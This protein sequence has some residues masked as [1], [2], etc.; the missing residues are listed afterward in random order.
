MNKRSFLRRLN[1][2]ENKFGETQEM[3]ECG[4][5]IVKLLREYEKAMEPLRQNPNS[6][7]LELEL[8]QECIRDMIEEGI[9][10]NPEPMSLAETG[11]EGKQGRG[12]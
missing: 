1:A 2:L 8:V 3:K 10:K 6:A 11:A 9:L 7:A 12:A 5:E 4:E